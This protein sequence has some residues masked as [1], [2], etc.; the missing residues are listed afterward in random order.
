MRKGYLSFLNIIRFKNNNI[1][2]IC[3]FVAYNV[4]EI[5]A[6]TYSFLHC[7]LFVLYI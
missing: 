7:I 3:L 6:F 1:L 4:I 2:L 5:H